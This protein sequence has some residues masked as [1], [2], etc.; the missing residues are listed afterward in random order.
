MI[1]SVAATVASSAD[2]A[3]GGDAGSGAR[4]A[5]ESAGKPDDAA[6]EPAAAVASGEV[7]GTRGAEELEG[8]VA[9]QRVVETAELKVEP[10]GNTREATSGSGIFELDCCEAP[11]SS[12]ESGAKAD[13]S[14]GVVER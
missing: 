12:A 8:G 10:C 1:I 13:A 6:P 4:A 2:S 3:R 9:L 11:S 5:V 7:K 14:S